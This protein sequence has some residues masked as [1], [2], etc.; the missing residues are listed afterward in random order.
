MCVCKKGK[1][2]KHQLFLFLIRGIK[3]SEFTFRFLNG[4]FFSSPQPV[5]RRKKGLLKTEK[6]NVLLLTKIT[7]LSPEA[8]GEGITG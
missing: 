5:F 4:C 8:G 7:S 1:K 6:R 2:K 3:F